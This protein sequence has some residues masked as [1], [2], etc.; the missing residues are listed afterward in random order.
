M[1]CKY[2]FSVRRL[3]FCFVDGF[4]FTVAPVAKGRIG[5]AAA[6]LDPSQSNAGSEPH[7]QPTQQL[8][9]MPDLQ[10]TE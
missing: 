6:S 3:S 9:A 5:A 10:P 4:L 7:M 1:I 2:F 8:V